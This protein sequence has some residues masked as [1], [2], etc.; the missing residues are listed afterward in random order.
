MGPYTLLRQ[1][2][3][4]GGLVLCLTV[5]A[6][7]GGLWGGPGLSGRVVPHRLGGSQHQP[8]RGI[9]DDGDLVDFYVYTLCGVDRTIHIAV[10][11]DMDNPMTYASLD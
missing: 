10:S 8:R 7:F 3:D 1:R 2:S 9:T 4:L 6:F 5:S 11:V